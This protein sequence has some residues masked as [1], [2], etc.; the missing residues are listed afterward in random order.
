M[1]AARLVIG[2]RT[3]ETHL[4]NLMRKLGLR[5]RAELVRYA[6]RRGVARFEE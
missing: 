3:A 6:F 2:R 5:G 4:A 1:I